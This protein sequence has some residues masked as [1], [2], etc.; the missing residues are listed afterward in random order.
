MFTGPDPITR[1]R[2][3]DYPNRADHRGPVHA[4]SGYSAV[5]ATTELP[6][7]A[8]TTPRA[9]RP[10]LLLP[11]CSFRWVVPYVWARRYLPR[12]VPKLI[13]LDEDC[14]VMASGGVEIM[15]APAWSF[16]PRP[17]AGWQ[18][19]RGFLLA[20]FPGNIAQYVNKRDG[21]GLDSDGSDSSGCCSSRCDGVA[22]WSMQCRGART[23]MIEPAS[24][25]SAADLLNQRRPGVP[26]RTTTKFRCEILLRISAL[27]YERLLL[28]KDFLRGETD[29]VALYPW[30]W[31]TERG[32]ELVQG[33]EV[34]RID[35]GE[36]VAVIKATGIRHSP[37]CWRSAHTGAIAGRRWRAGTATAF[38]VGC[39]SVSARPVP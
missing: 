8:P 3:T 23:S 15:S 17:R 13:R 27:P 9:P 24:S 29:D 4:T 30:S 38:A 21:S 18:A 6:A 31:F 36:G 35:P 37:S 22:V 33:V 7:P 12:P 1:T 5:M 14:V 25:S 34:D 28:S 2:T 39:S 32:I 10:A 16:R 20:V 11:A 19:D 26:L